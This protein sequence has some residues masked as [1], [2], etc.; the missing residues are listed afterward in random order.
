MDGKRFDDV[1]KAASGGAPWHAGVRGVAGGVLGNLVGRTRSGET[2]A[3]SRPCPPGKTRC[4]GR[5]VGPDRLC[6]GVCCRDGGIC[7]V[8]GRRHRQCFPSVCMRQTRPSPEDECCYDWEECA[9]A[10]D[11]TGRACCRREHVCDDAAGDKVCCDGACCGGRCV[12]RCE[13]ADQCCPGVPCL[14]AQDQSGNICCSPDRVCGDVCCARHYSCSGSTECL[15]LGPYP[16]YRR[17]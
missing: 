3:R 11:G 12:V 16:R 15:P 17:G 9:A 14:L 2:A 13:N 4:N 5:C 8:Y 1:V 10:A 6:D 7:C